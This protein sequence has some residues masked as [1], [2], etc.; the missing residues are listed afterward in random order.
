MNYPRRGGFRGV[1]L[2]ATALALAS[3]L[4][5]PAALAQQQAAASGSSANTAAPAPLS[6]DE[7]EV[8]VARIALYPDELVA[9]ITSASLYPLQ[10]VEAARFLDQYE[11]DNSLKP[12]DSWDGSVVSLLN[13]PEIVRIMS[14]D[15]EWTQQLGDAVAWQ[16]KDV[17]V[18]IQQLREEAVANG[19]IKSDEKMTVQTSGDNIVI[20]STNP[21][22]VYVPRYEPQMLYEPGY[23]PAPVTYY[24][25]PYP[26]YWY[27]TATF[28]AGAVTGAAWAAAVD[29]DDWG[30]WGGRW[31]GNDIDV[32][33]NNCFNNRN[34]NGKVDFNDIDWKNVD[35]SKLKIDRDQFNKFDRTKIKNRVERNPDNRIQNRASEIK[36]N[37]LAARRGSENRPSSADVRRN[38]EQG[39]KRPDAKPAPRPDGGN[40]A[41]RPSGAN[42]D[43]SRPDRSDRPVGKPRPGSRA[44]DRPKPSALGNV[45][46]GKAAKIQSNR[47]AKAMGGGQRAGGRAMKKPPSGGRQM[48][49]GGGGRDGG[50]RGGGGGR[51]R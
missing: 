5:V 1:V 33:C 9:L 48:H 32:D 27:P 51:R 44:D 21:E 24:P 8:L 50:G 46:R 35:R 42:R 38:I 10:I 22:V 2:V 28:F 15:L 34:F 47:G 13:Y 3:A 19:V 41:N 49:R 37:D 39:L 40:V 6:A 23:V 4:P 17:L 36:R 29:W 16:Q 20:Q 30:V 11:K 31:D 18:A 25:E 14:D 43:V 45:D 26:N 12:K 7:M